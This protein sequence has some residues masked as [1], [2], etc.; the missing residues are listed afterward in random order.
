MIKQKKLLKHQNMFLQA[1]FLFPDKRFHFL[2]CGYG[3][4]KSSS[5]ATAVE[6]AISLVNGLHDKENHGPRLMLAGKSIDHL[7]KTTFKYIEEDLKNTG[8]A[9]RFD[10]KQNILYVGNVMVILMSLA[11]PEKIAGYDVWAAFLDEVDDLGR[12]VSADELTFEA[13]KAA[14]ERVRQSIVGMRAPFV[15]MAST[16]QGTKGLY[17]VYNSF[18]KNG[19]G[20]SLIHGSS[21]DNPYV[22]KTWLASLFEMYTPL[23]QQVFIHGK[24]IQLQQGQV[25][26]A[27]DW[28]IHQLPHD[29]Y[30]EVQKKGDT[31]YIG[32]DFNTGYNRGC[33]FVF[34]NGIVYAIKRYEFPDPS[35]APKVFR[36][37]FPKSKII[38]IPDTTAKDKLLHFVRELYKF[39]IFTSIRRSN[40]LV[41]DTVFLVNKLLYTKRL[42]FCPMA[43]ETE[44]AVAGFAR[45]DNNQIP[46]GKTPSDY[47]HDV[48]GVRYVA[49]YLAATK[50][51]LIDI[52]RVT[53]G[54]HL[55]E[56]KDEEK[57]Q[58]VINEGGGFTQITPAGYV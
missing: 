16:S 50:V 29:M 37:D 3:A 27:H 45:D 52:Q 28:K 11:V 24:F 56:K 57:M 43:K 40:P 7:L 17:R 26:P 42:F 46:K 44:E 55:E 8:T 10:S 30:E 47:A 31:V 18:K 49:Y 19:T 6:Y 36:Y 9:Y 2:V 20:F 32:M 25:F 58:K 23:E 35:D 33:A 41:E 5:M 48:D 1:P 12:K 22:D 51:E 53:I 39:K 54:R 4:G 38:Y 13:V 21:V 34:R 15:A 14:N